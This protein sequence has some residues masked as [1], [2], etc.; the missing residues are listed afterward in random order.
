MFFKKGI[1][2]EKSVSI[3]HLRICNEVLH[4]CLRHHVIMIDHVVS[5]TMCG[6]A[7]NNYIFYDCMPI[8]EQDSMKLKMI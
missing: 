6:I 1:T 2:K 5:V 8:A 3:S 7:A 4:S